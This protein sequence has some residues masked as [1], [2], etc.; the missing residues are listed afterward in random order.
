ML[1]ACLN[2]LALAAVP[3]L[4]A[5]AASPAISRALLDDPKLWFLIAL[6]LVTC[7]LDL[8]TK[9]PMAPMLVSPP[10]RSLETRTTA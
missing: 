2:I 7:Y 3:T 4:F 1:S 8:L 9:V 5:A 6:S 10:L